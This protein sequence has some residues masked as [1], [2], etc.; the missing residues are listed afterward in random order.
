MSDFIR[1]RSDDQ[2]QQR[3]QQIKSATDA[4][5]AAQPYHEI[6][7]TTIAEKLGCSRAHLYKYVT[8][9]EEIFL[10]LSADKRNDYFAALRAA[11][12]AGCAYAPQVLAEVWAEILNCHQSYLR[13]CDI[14]MSIIETNVT[15]ERLA[16]FK[17]NYYEGAG[18]IISLL[19][20]N[21]EIAAEKAE[22]LFYA[23]YYHAVGIGSNCTRNPLIQ[24]ALALI[25][26]QAAPVDFRGEMREF[27]KMCLTFY[28]PELC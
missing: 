11:F 21:L 20:Q 5:F 26:M 14:L 25:G 7:L 9:K 12:P 17:K 4:L 23:V 16:A 18:E 24:Q 8:T 3:M 22:A 10:E 6:T 19:A 27:I 2:K 28:L 15:V 1:A 13:Y